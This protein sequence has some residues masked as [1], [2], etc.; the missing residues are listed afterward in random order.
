MNFKPL[1]FGAKCPSVFPE[2]KTCQKIFIRLKITSVQNVAI[3]VNEFWAKIRQF[4]EGFRNPNRKRSSDFVPSMFQNCPS[5][6]PGTKQVFRWFWNPYDEVPLSWNP[7][8]GPLLWDPTNF[9]AL[10]RTYRRKLPRPCVRRHQMRRRYL[11]CMNMDTLQV[12]WDK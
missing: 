11:M 10:Y 7:S 1:I 3:F 8:E 9:S 5:S 2:T 12:V 6:S 4:F